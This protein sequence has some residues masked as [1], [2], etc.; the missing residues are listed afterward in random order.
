MKKHQWCRQGPWT[1]VVTNCSCACSKASQNTMQ[2]KRYTQ[3]VK[4]KTCEWRLFTRLC[5]VLGQI[6]KWSIPRH[7]LR[8]YWISRTKTPWESRYKMSW[9][10]PHWFPSV[11]V[12]HKP[13]GTGEDA[14][15][16]SDCTSSLV[17]IGWNATY[18]PTGSRLHFNTDQVRNEKMWRKDNTLHRFCIKWCNPSFKYA[19][20]QGS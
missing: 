1:T 14:D 2:R 6:P 13:L 3:H 5:R 7:I 18:F 11:R 17:G 9:R 12:Q 20:I 16:G 15:C 4:R 10:R 19:R 8:R